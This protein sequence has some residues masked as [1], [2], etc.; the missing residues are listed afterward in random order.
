LSLQ[1]RTLTCV[2]LR[3]NLTRHAVIFNNQEVVASTRNAVKALDLDWTGWTSFFDVLTE[4]IEHT[5]YA[6][7]G[8]AD[9]DGV[10]HAQSTALND[11]GCDWTTTTVEVSFDGNTLCVHV[12]VCS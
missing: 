3:C 8:V 9:N 4:L 5:A 11:N 1:C 6:T 10:T 2:T 12:W 7:E